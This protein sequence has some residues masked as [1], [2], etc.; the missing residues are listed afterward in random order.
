M[1]Q[2]QAQTIRL[3]G[4]ELAYFERGERRKGRPTLLFVHATGFHGRVWDRIIESFPGYHTLALELRGHGRS[5]KVPIRHWREVGEDIAAFAKALQ[6]TDLIGI[7]HSMGAHGLVDGAAI[8]GAFARLILL[9]PVIAAPDA[10]DDPTPL[11]AAGVHPASKRRNHFSSVDEMIERLLPKSSFGLFEARILDDYCRYG[12]LP[13]P[14]G[15]YVLACP[16]DIEASVYMTARTN[17]AIYDSVRS[18][19]IPVTIMRAQIRTAEGT[20][21]DFS[22]SPT[23]PGLVREFS[24]GRELHLEGC[25]HFI[26]MQVPD[27]VVAVIA[28]EV[29]Q[30]SPA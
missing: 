22:T 26:P 18:L 15:G 30:W 4:V 25:S 5:E 21:P 8:G 20:E 6:L 28:E 27:D 16:P 24:H 23:W 3:N 2:I 13:A 11:A 19:Q 9:D 10:Y 17:G 14:G 12:L 1:K 29:A 7:G